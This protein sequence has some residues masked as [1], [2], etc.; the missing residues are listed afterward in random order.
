[1]RDRLTGE[2]WARTFREFRTSAWRWETQGVY[3]EPYEQEPLRRFLAG[4]QPDMSFMDDWLSGVRDASAHGRSFGRVRVLTEP[5]TDYLRFELSFTPLNVDAGEDVRVLPDSRR[6][7]L[8]LPQEDFWL[9]DDE[10][11]ALM[12]FGDQGF[13]HA[14]V[15]RDAPTLDLFREIRHLAWKDAIPF[16][17][18]LTS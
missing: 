16:R 18:Y 13:S 15:V 11:A 8:D 6:A 10:W 4:Q 5:L 9:F 1:M 3:R 17:D 14:E 12:Y 7:E 2:T